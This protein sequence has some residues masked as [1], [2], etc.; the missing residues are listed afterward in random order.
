MRNQ[1]QNTDTTKLPIRPV[2]IAFLFRHS[3][4]SQVLLLL[5][6]ACS[7]L[8]LLLLR[9]WR[10]TGSY[11]LPGLRPPEI[12]IVIRVSRV[13]SGGKGRMLDVRIPIPLSIERRLTLPLLLLVLV[14][15]RWYIG[16]VLERLLLVEISSWRGWEYGVEAKVVHRRLPSVLPIVEE[17]CRRRRLIRQRKVDQW[18]FY[19]F[20]F[21]LFFLICKQIAERNF[22]VF[23]RVVWLLY[24]WINNLVWFFFFFL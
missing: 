7:L 1:N 11:L 23:E 24:R 17:R 13:L 9:Q 14:T 18:H 22:D 3:R 10:C 21:P 16:L 8:L 5:F 6:H 20:F 19:S 2:G 12:L 4:R 15:D